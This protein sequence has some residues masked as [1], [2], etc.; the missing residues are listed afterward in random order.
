MAAGGGGVGSD[1][2]AGEC[3][4]SVLASSRG[5]ATGFNYLANPLTFRCVRLPYQTRDHRLDADPAI[6]IAFEDDHDDDGASR[7]S[8]ST[9]SSLPTR[10]TTE[11]GRSSPSPPAPVTGAWAPTSAH[12][13]WSSRG[14]ALP[15]GA[16]PSGAPPSA[17]TAAAS[18]PSP[19]PE[20][21]YSEPTVASFSQ[22]SVPAMRYT[23]SIYQDEFGL[24]DFA[25]ILSVSIV[26][27]YVGF[28]VN[29]YGRVIARDS[30][31]YR[32]IYLFHH[33]RDDCQRFTEG[34][35]LMLTGPSGVYRISAGSQ[36]EES[37]DDPVPDDV[38]EHD[39]WLDI[40]EGDT[41]TPVEETVKP[42]VTK[43]AL[44]SASKSNKRK[45]T[46]D[47]SQSE[48]EDDDEAEDES[49]DDEDG[50]A[51]GAKGKCG[52][53]PSEDTGH[54][55]PREI[56]EWEL[57]MHEAAEILERREEELRVAK[58]EIEKSVSIEESVM[59]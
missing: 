53:K 56:A 50:D 41:S 19:S 17:R 32:C 27:S 54:M 40:Y 3:G 10:C 24:E 39:T 36:S 28:P 25:N 48:E 2:A 38:V 20:S 8:T 6:V 34:G 18:S 46:K 57:E 58:D 45:K 30:I 26:S 14:R 12:R 15:R 43:K 9:T 49:E 42:K 51:R 7:G 13:R 44:P 21:T 4:V 11:S 47:L 35:M 16:V 22:A 1:R 23:D 33:N 31:D 52:R 37:D 59:E 55:L 5:L 29:V